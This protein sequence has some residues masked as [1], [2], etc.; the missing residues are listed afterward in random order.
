MQNNSF[1]QFGSHLKV[2]YGPFDFTSQHKVYSS[3]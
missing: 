2:I 1:K 3:L